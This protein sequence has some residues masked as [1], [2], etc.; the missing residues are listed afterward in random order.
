MSESKAITVIQRHEQFLDRQQDRL[1]KWISPGSGLEASALKRFALHDI[2]VNPKLA[3]C[4]EISIYLA[5]LACAVSGLEPGSMKQEAFL[6]P[7][8]NTYG[9]RKVM[10]ATFMIGWRGIVRQ[11][12]RAGINIKSGVVRERDKFDFDRGSTP[13]ITHKEALGSRGAMQGTYA[14]ARLPDG[15]LD[16]EVMDLD[17]IGRIRQAAQRGKASPAWQQW[18]DEM[19]RKSAI[20]RLGKRLP[21]GRD[22][23]AGELVERAHHRG[24]DDEAPSGPRSMVDALN[25]LTEGEVMRGIEDDNAQAIVFSAPPIEIVSSDKPELVTGKPRKTSPA[26]PTSAS[27]PTRSPAS[28]ESTSTRES[29]AASKEATGSSSPVSAVPTNAGSTNPPVASPAAASSSNGGT[30]STKA[31]DTPSA[32]TQASTAIPEA[33]SS[34][35]TG[36]EPPSGN[37]PAND[38]SFG[39]F[40][41]PDDVKVV[42]SIPVAPK[43]C[44][45]AV[46]Q[47]RAWWET[48][49]A[50]TDAPGFL[51]R[52]QAFAALCAT[53]A[54]FDENRRPFM[55]YLNRFFEGPNATR[56]SA[57]NIYDNRIAQ[58]K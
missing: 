40:E 13:F 52:F 11:A 38:T 16:I 39:D 53:R 12:R 41:D 18:E 56:Q 17:T 7:F 49:G 57:K 51:S 10:E 22:Y 15:D 55:D 5:L 43:T 36:N 21:L 33:A 2:Q 6:V 34:A 20:R 14:W 9:D 25:L 24:D 19:A 32:T 35:S 37:A 26:R 29:G 46:D 45:E 27:E 47:L 44:T 42:A 1:V 3:Q 28:S 30:A 8:Q 48:D 23:Y 54:E 50:G 31:S 58:F 4:T